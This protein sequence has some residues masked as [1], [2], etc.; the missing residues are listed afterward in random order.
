MW[1]FGRWGLRGGEHPLHNGLTVE[2]RGPVHQV[3]RPEEHREHDT[4]HLVDLAHAVVSL[5]GVQGLD[6]GGRAAHAHAHADAYRAQ[7][8]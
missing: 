6:V 7:L 3:E 2:V 8:H 5:L 4:G 1:D